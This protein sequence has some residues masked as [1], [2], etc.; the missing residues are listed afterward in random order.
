MLRYGDSLLIWCI[1]LGRKFAFSACAQF[2]CMMKTCNG[3]TI[4]TKYLSKCVCCTRTA[5]KARHACRATIYKMRVNKRDREPEIGCSLSLQVATNWILCWNNIGALY[6]CDVHA[7]NAFAHQAIT[8]HK[9]I[10]LFFGNC[11]TNYHY[12]SMASVAAL[13]AY[14][15][16]APGRLHSH[17]I[18]CAFV[19]SAVHCALCLAACHHHYLYSKCARNAD[20][21]YGNSQL[22][23]YKY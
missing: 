4:T 19:M 3:Q 18:Y 6:V 17:C 22:K 14:G 1:L 11:V 7:I 13:C 5:A 20:T 9:E 21:P 16:V 15:A 12:L 23:R 10:S 2:I 8:V